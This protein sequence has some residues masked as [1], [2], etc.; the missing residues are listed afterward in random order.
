[1]IDLCVVNYNT[2]KELNRFL[3]S[4][5]AVRLNAPL[6]GLGHNTELDS[7]V[8]IADNDSKDYSRSMLKS[9]GLTPEAF[10]NQV[11]FNE[12]IG[13]AKACN[14]LATLGRNSIIGFCNADVWMTRKDLQAIEQFFYHNEEAAIVGP[15][16]RDEKNQIVHAGI[17]GTHSAPKHRGWK[18]LDPNDEH[19]RDVIECVTVS[20][21]AYFIR[22]SVWDELTNYPPYRELFPNV[23]GAFLPT[24]HYYEETFCSYLAGH[25]GHK[26]FYNGEVS[27]G[28]SWHAS[29]SVGS[30]Q[31]KMFSVSRSIFRQTCDDLGISHD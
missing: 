14:Q 24:P 10:P 18:K 5:M 20:G 4:L 7:N 28:H 11:F 6:E 21:S 22:R 17:V 8:Y 19:F 1:M 3:S 30:P 12:N 9:F 16:Q 25:L 13:Y 27:I 31:D 23:E 29:H 15:K 2:H 26:V